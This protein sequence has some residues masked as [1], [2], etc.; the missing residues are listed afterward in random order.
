MGR[1]RGV[2][3]LL[4]NEPAQSR[5]QKWYVMTHGVTVIVHDVEILTIIIILMLVCLQECLPRFLWSIK[6]MNPFLLHMPLGGYY[7]MCLPSAPLFYSLCSRYILNRVSYYISYARCI[8]KDQLSLLSLFNKQQRVTTLKLQG[9]PR[10]PIATF[11]SFK[12][13]G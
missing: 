5:L 11:S 2:W 7:C 3:A 13:I 12:Y 6:M 10:R 8:S 9:E 4:D 1:S